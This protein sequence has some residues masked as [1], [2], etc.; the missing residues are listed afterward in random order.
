[1]CVANQKAGGVGI[2]LTAASAMIYFA[3]SYSLEDDAQSERRAYRGGSEGHDKILRYDLVCENTIDED[4]NEAL[5][6]K[7]KEGELLWKIKNK[8]R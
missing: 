2:D 8:L 3:K 5:K 6:A 7:M 1:M 4:I